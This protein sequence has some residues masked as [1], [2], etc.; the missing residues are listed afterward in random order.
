MEEFPLSSDSPAV[1]G[2][3]E[4]NVTRSAAPTRIHG[5]YSASPGI[6]P[7][8]ASEARS[9]TRPEAGAETLTETGTGTETG[10]GPGNGPG[11]TPE[12]AP[13]LSGLDR[14]NSAPA[15]AVEAALHA[16]CGSR[17]WARRLTVH[18]PYPDLDALLAAAD[19]A[20]YDLG[21]ADLAE[22]LADESAVQQPPPGTRRVG[23]LAAHTALRAAHAAY[24]SRFGHVFVICVDSFRPTE[25][26]GHV[27]AG[28]R[29]RLGNDRDEERAVSADEMRR[30]ARG[31][32]THLVAN[33]P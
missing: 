21:P 8:T 20:S 33:R 14:L 31:R 13:G 5:P 30:I 4:E 15:G 1:H 10:I 25:V 9:R 11:I 26:L 6:A 22:A 12:T 7:T 16:C 19:E 24:E 28:I 27:L 17:R 2:A 3:P 18:R 32:L 23:T 29:A